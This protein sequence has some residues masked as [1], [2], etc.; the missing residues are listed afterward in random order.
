MLPELVASSSRYSSSALSHVVVITFMPISS[1]PICSVPSLMR[2]LAVMV[3]VTG[4]QYTNSGVQT[5][6][7]GDT[8]VAGGTSAPTS[9][10]K[11]S[12]VTVNGTV[13]V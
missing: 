9:L 8:S 7:F 13:G 12:S 6:T 3:R 4:S 5:I 10:R 1:V 2:A 11:R